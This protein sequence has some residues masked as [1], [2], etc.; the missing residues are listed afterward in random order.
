[1]DNCIFCKIARGEIPSKKIYEDEEILGFHDINPQAPVHF[2]LMPKKHIAS[3]ADATMEDAGML[4]RLLALSG[5][6]AREQG[7]PD[8]YRTI[9]NTGRI[10]RQDVM[11]LHVHVIGGS[12]PLGRMLPK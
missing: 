11:H 6:L 2:M 10:G 5:R 9:I 12:E 4:G 1:M 8:G 7:S 3:L